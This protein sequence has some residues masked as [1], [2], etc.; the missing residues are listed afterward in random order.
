M[1]S[2]KEIKDV[3][4]L[5]QEQL[6]YY[7]RD[8]YKAR[9]RK[10]FFKFNNYLFIEGTSNAC[11]VAHLDT[12]HSRP[13]VNITEEKHPEKTIFSSK[14]GIGADDR[15][16]V[17]AA[18]KLNELNDNSLNLLFT[19]NEEIGG[20]GVKRFI[21]GKLFNRVKEH[22]NIF[23]EFDRKGANDYVLYGYR[24]EEV[25]RILE[26]VGFV[27]GYGSYSDVR[28]LSD[29]GVLGVNLSA[30]YYNQ[31]RK[32]EYF[33]LEE[34]E[35]NIT[36]VNS[37]LQELAIKKRTAIL[38]PTLFDEQF[39][40]LSS[41]GTDGEM[42]KAICSFYDYAQMNGMAGKSAI[43]FVT[44]CYEEWEY[45]LRD[46]PEII[47]TAVLDELIMEVDQHVRIRI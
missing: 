24:D 8:F 40:G 20:L 46:S 4:K 5:T 16:G 23:L 42:I 1:I 21:K 35:Y 22:I 43:E 28:T 30:G 2:S 7:L 36:R 12:V 13:P 38:A 15:C 3:F 11:V 33:V 41:F 14:A 39:S 47:A 18:I 6:G 29:N 37:I 17:L 45:S 19:F 26:S 31:H 9:G 10:V 27:E 25:Q 44:R 34:L 32:N